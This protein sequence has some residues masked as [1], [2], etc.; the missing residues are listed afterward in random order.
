MELKEFLQLL[1]N[2]TINK[3]AESKDGVMYHM[4]GTVI[5]IELISYD[6]IPKDGFYEISEYTCGGGGE[7]QPGSCAIGEPAQR[8]K[9]RGIFDKRECGRYSFCNIYEGCGICGI[10]I[11]KCFDLINEVLEKQDD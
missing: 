7:K 3:F 9:D 1:E 6:K 8:C 4:D 10:G 11:L 2:R 5:P